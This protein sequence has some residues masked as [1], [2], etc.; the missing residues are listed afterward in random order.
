MVTVI[1]ELRKVMSLAANFMLS[2]PFYASVDITNFC[3]LGCVE[4]LASE[5]ATPFALP[6]DYF[7]LPT[8]TVG[9]GK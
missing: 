1:N 9:E 5:A 6:K 3:N 8:V 7:P 2:R 4:I